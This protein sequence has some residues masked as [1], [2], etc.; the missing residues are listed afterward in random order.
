M[1]RS[2]GVMGSLVQRPAHTPKVAEYEQDGMRP[3]MGHIAW[4]WGASAVGIIQKQLKSLAEGCWKSGWPLSVNQAK[5]DHVSQVSTILV[6][7][8]VQLH[9]DQRF[10][11]DDSLLIDLHRSIDSGSWAGIVG[12]HLLVCQQ[13]MKALAWLAI[14]AIQE[15]DSPHHFI[16]H[17]PSAL[18]CI[19]SAWQIFFCEKQVD[20]AR[21]AHGA[22]VDRSHP[23]GN[24]I[25][26]N[27]R[28]G[29]L[30]VVKRLAG[31]IQS[32]LNQFH[33]TKHPLENIE[34][35]LPHPICKLFRFQVRSVPRRDSKIQSSVLTE[36]ACNGQT[37]KTIGSVAGTGDPDLH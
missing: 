21:V 9:L 26:A 11:L 16:S 31:A 18:K 37:Q 1:R 23:G 36:R 35:L 33:G 10:E 13:N 4:R 34:P 14:R 25:A 24:R 20:I 7:K 19:G 22:I 15:D 6:P 5:L 32:F 17:K 29:N 8:A 2:L 30:C 12:S 28:V 3:K 27:D